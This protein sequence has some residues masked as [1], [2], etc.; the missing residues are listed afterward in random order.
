MPFVFSTSSALSAPVAENDILRLLSLLSIKVS[1]G[2]LHSFIFLKRVCLEVKVA[3]PH[4]RSRHFVQEVIRVSSGSD[5]FR[6]TLQKY[7]FAQYCPGIIDLALI[8]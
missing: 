8:L 6:F 4:H 2:I 5:L 3:S 7:I 1:S